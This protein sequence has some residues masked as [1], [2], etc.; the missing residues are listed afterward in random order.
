MNDEVKN[1][2]NNAVFNWDLVEAHLAEGTYSGYKSAIIEMEKIFNDVLKSKGI[3]FEGE[4]LLSKMRGKILEPE[5]LRY[6]RKIYE[7][8]I[9]QRDYNPTYF[10]TRNTVEGYFLAANDIQNFK[11]QAFLYKSKLHL[12]YSGA[13]SFLKRFLIL[14]VI[15]FILSVIITDTN[16]G[17]SFARYLI[18]A[19]KFFVYKV[20]PKAGIAFGIFI[21]YLVVLRIV[22]RKRIK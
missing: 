17:R 14:A 15:V 20:L 10:E 12:L 6:A 2:E 18:V 19:S 9:S 8:I 7:K 4:Q 21:I 16:L 13:I 3:N 5:K 11:S 1:K 22:R